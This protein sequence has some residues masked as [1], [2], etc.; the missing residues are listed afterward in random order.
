MIERYKKSVEPTYTDG[1][2]IDP[3]P[4]SPAVATALLI[5]AGLPDV[6]RILVN[7]A[8]KQQ[9]CRE[10]GGVRGWL[11]LTRPWHGHAAHM[12]IRSPCPAGQL[13]TL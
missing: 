8:I 12:H 10:P 1:R 4:R 2:D 7:P 13:V 5:Y 9:F 6:D 3:A 11:H